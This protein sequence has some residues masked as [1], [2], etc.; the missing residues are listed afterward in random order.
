MR[1]TVVFVT[2]LLVVGAGA[3]FAAAA[4]SATADAAPAS[5][6]VDVQD[7]DATNE[8]ENETAPGAQLAGVA[9]VQGAEVE[10]E[11]EKRTFGLKVAAANSNASKA[12]VVAEQAET[13]DAQL[14]ALQERRVE[15]EAA[16]ENGTISE[17]EFRA[18]IA[19]L[20]ARIST[21]QELTNATAETAKGLPAEALAERG[22]NASAIERIQTSAR[23]LS[24][25]AVAQIAR[26]IAGPPGGTVGPATNVSDGPPFGPPGEANR[27]AGG[28]DDT[29]GEANRTTGSPG[30]TPANDAETG[31]PDDTPANNSTGENATDG[32]GAGNGPDDTPG[33][34]ASAGNETD[35]PNNGS[36]VPGNGNGES[37]PTDTSTT[38]SAVDGPAMV[39]DSYSVRPAAL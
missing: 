28:P 27:T 22:V 11:V 26:G 23:N 9:D 6:A 4:P 36:D 31:A 39:T 38:V 12:S 29:P 35:V 19:G 15:L 8:S 3:P 20:A 16:R 37:G 7:D 10:G 17:S 34:N 2:A 5:G 21:L 18:K 25:P 14:Q 32:V 1:A 24:G 13:L 33:R 30:D